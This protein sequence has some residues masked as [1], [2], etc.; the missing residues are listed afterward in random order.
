MNYLKGVLGYLLLGGGLGAVIFK[1]FEN[2]SEWS[3]WLIFI[4]ISVGF[5]ITFENIKQETKE[6]VIKEID[7]KFKRRDEKY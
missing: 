4:L 6:E 7:E 5:F 2:T 1:V 3:Q